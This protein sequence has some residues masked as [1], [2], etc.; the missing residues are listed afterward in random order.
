MSTFAEFSDPEYDRSTPPPQRTPS[1]G[2]FLTEQEQRD[3]LRHV[4]EIRRQL[5]HRRPDHT[6]TQR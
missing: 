1:S 2:R 4:D 6:S 5:A 3:G